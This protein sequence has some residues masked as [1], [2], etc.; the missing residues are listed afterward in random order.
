MMNKLTYFEEKYLLTFSNPKQFQAY[1]QNFCLGVHKCRKGSKGPCLIVER[2][3]Y[4]WF[5]IGQQVQQIH[6]KCQSDIPEI[7]G[8]L[9]KNTFFKCILCSINVLGS[10]NRS[11]K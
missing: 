1:K 8:F 2:F 9:V 11:R 7:N 6:S 5:H 10:I 4:Y 3:C